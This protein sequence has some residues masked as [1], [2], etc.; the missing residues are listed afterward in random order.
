MFIDV[1]TEDLVKRM[2]NRRICT[3][4]GHVYNLASNPPLNDSV[5]DVDGSPIVQRPDDHEDTVRARMTEQI[6]PLL[7]VVD[8]YRSAG[9]LRTV[10][11]RDPI[12]E[13]SAAVQAATA[14]IAGPSATKAAG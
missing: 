1:P 7:E 13:V 4:H 12:A 2:A 6:P 10:D 5:C 8:H 14:D 3:A 11:G 9:I